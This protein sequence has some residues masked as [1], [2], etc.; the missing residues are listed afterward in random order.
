[1]VDLIPL[2]FQRLIVEFSLENKKALET[3]QRR[4]EKQK[5]GY[6][7]FPELLIEKKIVFCLFYA[8]PHQKVEEGI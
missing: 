8:C 7:F 2:L 5:V 1:M 3:Q 4:K 6:S